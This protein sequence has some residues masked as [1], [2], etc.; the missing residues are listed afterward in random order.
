MLLIAHGPF[1]C[2]A[3][4]ALMCPFAAFV[5]GIA[6]SAD[7]RQ[8]AS[9]WRAVLGFGYLVA[10]VVYAYLLISLTLASR[11]MDSNG[12]SLL[13][14]LYVF[15]PTGPFV[16]LFI[17]ATIPKGSKKLDVDLTRRCEACGYDLTGNVSDVCPDCGSQ[18][19]FDS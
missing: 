12:T 13:S 6:W 4:L 9:P 11:A 15:S 16:A 18:I 10:S 19:P 5:V 17:L 7:G 14:G 1:A 2:F 8:F 3:L